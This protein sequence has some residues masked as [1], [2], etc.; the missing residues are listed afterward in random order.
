MSD[1][2]HAIGI[3]V[4]EPDGN[5]IE[6]SYEMPSSEWGHDPNGYMI[7]GT[8]HGRMPGPWGMRYRIPLFMGTA[9]PGA[10]R[11]ALGASEPLELLDTRQD[12]P[13]E[14]CDGLHHFPVVGAGVLETQVHHTHATLVMERL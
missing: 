1:Y 14:Q 6:V 13:A 4:R 12:F 9:L 10:V 7:G 8:Q 3:Y 5:G 11:P 2:G